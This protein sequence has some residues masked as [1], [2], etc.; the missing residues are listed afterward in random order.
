MNLRAKYFIVWT[1][2]WTWVREKNEF[3]KN[4][5]QIPDAFSIGLSF[6]QVVYAKAQRDPSFL[7]NL[8]A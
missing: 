3:W 6:K 2:D 8:V 1:C 7:M 4:E 5:W